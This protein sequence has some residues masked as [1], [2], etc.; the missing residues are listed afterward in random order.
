MQ[1]KFI[2]VVIFLL[3]GGGVLIQNSQP[4]EI[5]LFLWGPIK[6]SL[7]AVMVFSFLLG[8][9]LSLFISLVDQVK[10]RRTIKQQKKEI[11]EL[12]EKADLS[13]HISQEKSPR[14]HGDT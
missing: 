10:L 9:V 1:V 6:T 13:E 14:R 7:F 3:L 2:I 12:K 11:K 5:N 8:I 4:V